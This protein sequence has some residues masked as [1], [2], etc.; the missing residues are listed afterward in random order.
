MGLSDQR[1]FIIF[2]GI[3]NNDWETTFGRFTDHSEALVTEYIGIDTST[4]DSTQADSAC[5]D[6]YCATVRF[7]FPHHI[8]KQYYIEGVLQGEITVACNGGAS[9]ITDYKISVW[10]TNTDGTYERLAY[11]YS[12]DSEWI[13]VNDDLAWDAGNSIGE[14]K[15]Y[16]W[17]IDCWD[18]QEL[19][20]NDRIYLQI[21][22]RGTN[23]NLYLMHANDPEWIDV[24]AKIPFRL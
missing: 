22:I 11:T 21:E 24:W 12:N 10:K 7:L 20:E 8:K 14:E 18:A 1:D 9:H 17:Y 19:L 2:Y 3:K 5:T 15:V 23:T 6:G 13:P 4:S 16:H